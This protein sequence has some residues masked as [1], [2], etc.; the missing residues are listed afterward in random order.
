MQ[1]SASCKLPVS[2][3]PVN[4]LQPSG[5]G[6]TGMRLTACMIVNIVMESLYCIYP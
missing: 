6:S 3:V 1:I 4:P 2:L 5:G